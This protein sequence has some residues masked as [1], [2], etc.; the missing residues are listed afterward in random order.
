MEDGND[1]VDYD[2]KDVHCTLRRRDH[3]RTLRTISVAGQLRKR[4]KN[5]KKLFR[6]FHFAGRSG[7]LQCCWS[8]SSHQ[9][10][11]SFGPGKLF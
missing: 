7:Q 3:C 9:E 1:D 10:T 4:N 2:Y 5:K 6:I 11:G 8:D